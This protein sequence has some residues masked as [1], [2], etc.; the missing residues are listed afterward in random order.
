[1]KKSPGRLPGPGLFQGP[2]TFHRTG[3]TSYSNLPGVVSSKR[4]LVV[5]PIFENGAMLPATRR[6]TL[7]LV[8]G[9]VPPPMGVQLTRAPPPVSLANDTLVRPTARPVLTSLARC[10]ASWQSP[11]VP[12]LAS[13]SS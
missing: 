5:S 10:F 3:V 1:M 6:Q 11:P 2:G 8:T 4:R 12:R 13:A 7:Y 9:V